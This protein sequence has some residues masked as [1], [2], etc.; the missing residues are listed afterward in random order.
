MSNIV[1][2]KEANSQRNHDTS[3]ASLFGMICNIV[4][5]TVKFIIGSITNSV[6][7]T[8]DAFNNLSDAGVSLCA[9]IGIKKSS[10]GGDEEHPFSFGRV[11]YIFGLI[12]SFLIFLTAIEVGKIL[13]GKLF[14]HE[15]IEYNTF[16]IT[17]LCITVLMKL[18][19]GFYTKSI[20]TKTKSTIIQAISKDSLIDAVISLVTIVSMISSE[21]VSFP[22]DGIIGFA[23]VIW[24]FISGCSL[25]EENFNSIIGKKTIRNW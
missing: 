24:I 19:F 21:Y 17:I 9:L 13:F 10:K 25:A 1:M 6:A 4:L 2:G 11:E 14:T 16:I 7:I 3:K 23:V 12:I 22:I 15:I 8:G 5:F 18:G 20:A